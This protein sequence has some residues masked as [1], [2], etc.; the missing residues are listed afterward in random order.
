VDI[1]QEAQDTQ[2]TIQRP[3]ETQEKGRPKWIVWSFLEGGTNYPMKD[4]QR[5]NVE[6]TLK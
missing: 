4:L 2:D 3:H 6:Q 1:S 5:Q